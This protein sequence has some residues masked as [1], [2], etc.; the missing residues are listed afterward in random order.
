MQY[1]TFLFK[2]LPEN[3]QVLFRVVV[4]LGRLLDQMLHRALAV[5]VD[6][7]LF[8]L[9]RQVHPE[10]LHLLLFLQLVHPHWHL[11]FWDHIFTVNT[12][13]WKNLHF[14]IVKSTVRFL[15]LVQRLVAHILDQHVRVPFDGHAG[16]F[17][18]SETCFF[19]TLK[20]IFFKSYW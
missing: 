12:F 16:A 7:Q 11:C 13:F 5:H 18:V 4:S 1:I 3:R 15:L 9:H 6:G 2:K 10:Q 19:E 20:K 8:A 14:L 17:L